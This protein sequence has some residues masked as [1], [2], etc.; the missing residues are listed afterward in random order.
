MS[1]LY[2]PFPWGLSYHENAVSE[3]L[4]A[5]VDAWLLANKNLFVR[6]AP[7]VH[8]RSVAQFGN[9]AG[10]YEYKHAVKPTVTLPMPALM[11]ELRDTATPSSTISTP[12]A[13]LDHLIMN[14]YHRGQGI[15]PHIDSEEYGEDIVCFYI[16]RGTNHYTVSGIEQG[17]FFSGGTAQCLCAEW[18]CSTHVSSCNG[19][20]RTRR[21]HHFT[22]VSK[23]PLN[24]YLL[25]DDDGGNNPAGASIF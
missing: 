6:T 23:S 16:W 3:E 8:A 4:A 12:S 18:R 22:D 14:Q 17:S 15:R 20:T 5:R 11:Q 2:C 7:H 13:A 24:T 9:P 10:N 25:D 19:A 21:Y 1:Q